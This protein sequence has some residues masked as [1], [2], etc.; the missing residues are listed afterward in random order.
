[1]TKLKFTL[2]AAALVVFTL[3]FTSFAQAQATRTWVSGVGDDVNPCSRTAPCKTFAGAISKTAKDGE[4]DA[5]DPA[6][7]GTLTITKS[8][9]VNGTHGQGY[10]SVL[11]TLATGIIVNI[12]DPA[13]V[14]KAVRLRSLD[15]NGSSTG[16]HGISIIAASAVHVE[17]CVID[18]FLSA[19]NG[20]GIRVSDSDG[21]NLLVNNTDI[22]NCTT[23]VL[24]S[25]TGG[26]AV[27]NMTNTRIVSNG[28][29]ISLGANAF[30]TIKDSVVSSNSSN[31][32]ITTAGTA[33]GNVIESV[34]ANNGGTA[35]SANVSG[36]RLRIA[37]SD[38]YNNTVGVAFVAGAFVDSDARNRII[39]NGSTTAPNGV[40]P[41]Q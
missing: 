20:N 15:I 18:G 36:S 19:G 16:I 31:G 34:L 6:G 8:L 17:D 40:I 3:A 5:L 10:G 23:G 25:T 30:A 2:Q 28:T 13:D 41:Q 39:G 21:V 9:Y 24:M 37:S 26:F 4:I 22:H 1:M 11:A 32:V 12:T 38:V 7:F 27:A 35:I 14:R 33:V 29:G